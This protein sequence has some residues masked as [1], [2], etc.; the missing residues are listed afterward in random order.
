MDAVAELRASLRQLLNARHLDS[1][2]VLI[3]GDSYAP[4]KA[5]KIVAEG[6]AIDAWI[7]GQVIP[8]VA[9]SLTNEEIRA[10]Y[11]TNVTVPRAVEKEFALAYPIQR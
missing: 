5:A 7:P 2:P 4:I 6:Q 8:G 1:Q 9:L 10:L 11:R 3:A